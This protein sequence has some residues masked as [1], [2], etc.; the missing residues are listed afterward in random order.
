[1]KLARAFMLG[2]WLCGSLAACD[3]V[4][5]DLAPLPD[6]ASPGAPKDAGSK[7]RADAGP[8]PDPNLDASVGPAMCGKHACECDD[9]EDNDDDLLSDGFDPECTGPFDDD[10]HSFATSKMPG[11][12]AGMAC[13]GCFWNPKPGKGGDD[14]RYAAE[15]LDGRQPP[16]PGPG[17][18]TP[19]SCSCDVSEKCIHTC[20]DRTP[21]GCDCFGCCEVTRDDGSRVQVLLNE[22]CSLALLD[23]KVAC[24][25]CVPS[26]TCRKDCGTCELC[27]GR[28]R[29][30]LPELCADS[31]SGEVPQNV[32]DED[33]VCGADA[34][35][36][37][38]YYC[39]LGCCLYV[40]P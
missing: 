19:D 25:A 7:P 29:D 27:P 3:D 17:V 16:P 37:H 24:P 40:L 34:S 2:L 18:P 21:N 15:C 8:M 20:R 32:C 5:T 9:A 31:T 10:E 38:D 39:Q 6:A 23:D 14:C 33:I 36:P 22:R 1:M 12:P 28:T 35:C 26:A 11:P 4:T 30:E 13:R